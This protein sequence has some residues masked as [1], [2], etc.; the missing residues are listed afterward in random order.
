M[1]NLESSPVLPPLASRI[2]WDE[3][4]G[5]MLH[6]E[7]L[8]A[9]Q[10][11]ALD[12]L[13]PNEGSWTPEVIVVELGGDLPINTSGGLLSETGMPGLQL[14][15]E[16]VRQMRGESV[17]QVKGARKCIVSNQGGVMH[18]HSTLILGQ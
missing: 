10:V 3:F 13:L 1:M 12:L 18:T 15:I 9:A 4:G 8:T 11:V 16:G 6:C 17:N 2:K 14:V 5:P 7:G